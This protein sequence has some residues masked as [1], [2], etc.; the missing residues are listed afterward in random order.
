MIGVPSECLLA[1]NGSD[2]MLGYLIGTYLGKGKK[3]CTL[4]PDFSMYDYYASSYESETV[5]YPFLNE[6][7]T[8]VS[9]FISFA[10]S[11][12]ADMILFSNPNNPSGRCLSIKEIEQIVSSFT[13]PVVIDEAYMEFSSQESAISLLGKYGNLYVTRTLSKAYGLAGLRV[14]FLIGSGENMKRLK[15]AF[16]PY[17]LN[18][19]SMKIAAAV[20]GYADI[21]RSQIEEIKNERQRVYNC[22]KNFKRLKVYPSEANFLYGSSPFRNEMLDLLKEKNIVIRSYGDTDRFRITIGMPEENDMVLAVLNEFE[23]R[24]L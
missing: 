16:V 20:L 6:E 15:A 21:Y 2:Q 5:R 17:A 23:G 3:L 4:D 18:S 9:G 1:G 24:D 7:N 11:S 12:G 19:V 13:V 8:D 22:L 14:G 10:K